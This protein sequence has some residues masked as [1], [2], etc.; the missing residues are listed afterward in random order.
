MLLSIDV[1]IRNLGMCL[2]DPNTKKIHHWDASGIP[3]QHSNGLFVC[4]RD[5]LRARPWV[6]QSSKVLIEK[7]PDKNKTMKSVEHFLHAYF[8]CNDRDVQL[9][10]ARFKIPDV[11]GPGRAMYNKRKKESVI[12][13]TEFIKETNPELLDWFQDQK[14]KD[15][16]ADTVMQA[17]SF[18]NSAVA[19][20]S[21][22]IVKKQTPRKPTPN[23]T[24][25][26]YSRSNLAWLY[27]NGIKDQKRFDK[28]LRRYYNN[29]PEMLSE[30]TINA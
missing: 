7:Q 25:T 23:Q 14:K 27:I 8:L 19:S 17:L 5:H 6:L 15:D 12:R 26:K 2:I 18:I 22:K 20:S 11:V 24:D 29:L 3:P 1:G 4:L 9:Y 28:D 30:F 21:K 13:C 16:L 10:D